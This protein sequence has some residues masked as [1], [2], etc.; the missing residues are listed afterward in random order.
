[1]SADIFGHL[2]ALID[3]KALFKIFISSIKTKANWGHSENQCDQNI[4]QKCNTKPESQ[5]ENFDFSLEKSLRI[6]Y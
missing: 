1:M 4:K 3:K 5:H 2:G 6:S